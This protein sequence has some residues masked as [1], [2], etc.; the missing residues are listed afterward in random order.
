MTAKLTK[1][2]LIVILAVTTSS[3]LSA[4][5][6]SFKLQIQAAFVDAANATAG[7]QSPGGNYFSNSCR[8]RRLR[9][10]QLPG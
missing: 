10:L 2:V 8:L 6:L 7:S 9:E 1:A 4:R 3:H 5:K